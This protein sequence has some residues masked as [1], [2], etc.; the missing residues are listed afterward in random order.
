MSPRSIVMLL[1]WSNVAESGVVATKLDAM[2][3]A[4]VCCLPEW[5]DVVMVDVGCY[6]SEEGTTR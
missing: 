4:R 3:E 6:G 2:T 1:R 5:D